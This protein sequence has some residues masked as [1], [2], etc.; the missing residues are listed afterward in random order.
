MRQK[1]GTTGIVTDLSVSGNLNRLNIEPDDVVG[2]GTTTEQM[3]ILNVD[4]LNNSIRVKREH[5][6]VVG[7]SYT[8]PL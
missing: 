3:L 5:N 8:A 6:N 2:I 1:A 4:A 7:S